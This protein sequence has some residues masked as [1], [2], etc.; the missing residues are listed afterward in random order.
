MAWIQSDF[1][2]FEIRNGYDGIIR[3]NLFNGSDA[4]WR[5][6][7]LLDPSTSETVSPAPVVHHMKVGDGDI[8]AAWTDRN[9]YEV[10]ADAEKIEIHYP[11]FNGQGYG[12]ASYPTRMVSVDPA[13]VDVYQSPSQ[14]LL[15]RN[16]DNANSSGAS[17]TDLATYDI[18]GPLWPGDG[19]IVEV[20]AWGETANNANAKTLKLYFN[21]TSLLSESL[22]TGVAGH[23]R[24]KGTFTCRP[25]NSDVRYV[26]Q[27]FDNDNAGSMEVGTDTSCNVLD[28]LTVKITGQGTTTNDVALKQFIVRVPS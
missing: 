20:E 23:W 4:R 16:D 26:A 14:K 1:V 13:A 25:V 21:G 28:P 27:A 12:T 5:A 18:D 7:V 2:D 24:I 9:P 15:Y 3:N 10:A 11:S 8:L 6:H 22:T 19:S 17:E